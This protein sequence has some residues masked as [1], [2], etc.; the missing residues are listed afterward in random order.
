MYLKY[1]RLREAPFG[2]T[3]DPAFL[4]P[5]PS[6]REAI[7]SI[8]Y[9]V[10][11]RK[12]F[13]A[14]TGEVGTGKTIVLRTFMERIDS[15]KVQAIYL[16]NPE[17]SFNDL[18]RAMFD[19][20]GLE[21]PEVDTSLAIVY[22]QRYLIDL[23]RQGRWVTLLVDEAHRMPRETL[24]RLRL[25]SNLETSKD[26]LLQIVLCGQPEMDQVLGSYA[27]R[28]LRQRVAVRAAI[29]PLCRKESVAYI[30]HRLKRVSRM[31]NQVFS[32][33][34]L[35]AL[36]RH[37]HGNPRVL[38][39]LCDN[40]LIAGFAYQEKPISARVIKEVAVGLDYAMPKTRRTPKPEPAVHAEPSL[41]AYL[42]ASPMPPKPAP[43]GAGTV[44]SS[45]R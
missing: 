6:H 18:L 16:L 10:E 36:V 23:Y 31:H 5:S 32:Q 43:V 15:K 29:K 30:Q 19:A 14:L 39:I 26:K 20:L 33:R 41:D 11:H 42:D 22:L 25:L 34:G 28:Q 38:N 4:Y 2:I 21:V 17:L 7:A 3:P 8:I 35:Q 37:G 45:L 27:L 9:G 13:I 1:Y 44:Q 40:A 24:E 12:G